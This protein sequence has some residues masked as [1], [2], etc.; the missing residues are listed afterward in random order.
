MTGDCIHLLADENTPVCSPTLTKVDNV[1]EGSCVVPDANITYLICYAANGY[2]DT[3]VVITDSLPPEVNFV[4]ASNGGAYNPGNHTVTWDIGTLGPNGSNCLTLTVKVKP[5]VS[6]KPGTT[7]TNCCEMTG[8]CMTSAVTACEDT[9]VCADPRMIKLDFNYD[10]NNDDA[11]T[12][13]GFTKFIR[14]NSGSEVNGVII[15]LGGDIQSARRTDPC[16]TYGT[17]PDN[18]YYPRAGERI[19]RDFIYGIQPSGVTITLWEL[20]VNRD[21]DITIWAYDACST[22]DVNR[23]ANWYS[24]GTYIFDTNFIGGS[25][26]WP[27]Y[28]A[29]K[30]QDL[31]KYAF[32]G[33]A[34]T[35]YLGRIILESFADPCT[36]KGQ[37]FAFVNG[38]VVVPIGDFVPTKYAHRPV[39]FDGAEDVPVNVVLSWRPGVDA[40][41]HD[42]YLGTNFN[43]VNDANRTSHS[44][45]LIYEPNH[46]ADTFDP[47]G[48][49]GFLKLD[50]TYYWRVDEV[51]IS[52]PPIWKGEVWSFTTSLCAVV[53]NFNSYVTTNAL[54]QVWKDCWYQSA[55]VT[56]AQVFVQLGTADGN[57]VRDGNSMRYDY[58]N[59][60]SPYY[61]EARADIATLLPNGFLGQDLNWLAMGAKSLTLW[62]YGQPN[63]DANEKMYVKLADNGTPVR[64]A[65]VVYSGNMNDIRET[66]WH[67]WNIALQ[68]F[69][70]NNNVNLANVKTIT[71]GFG[72]GATRGTGRVY[73][74]DIRLCAPR[75]VLSKRSAN[76]AR[77]DY[78]PPG[79]PAGD[80]VIDYREIEMMANDWLMAPPPDPNIDLYGDGTIDFKDF[81]VLAEMWLEEELWP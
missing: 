16:G 22:G 81:A 11:N 24:N 52:L 77:V 57:L 17:P 64:T 4:W 7:I 21:C 37:P 9:Y 3:N 72:N 44:N 61:S 53:E 49:A 43:D 34:T 31:Y 42:V 27:G 39:P 20:G 80:C 10:A 68:D 45:L 60:A 56:R 19:Y 63:N 73:F 46:D 69:V 59:S 8:D 75:C 55:P 65:K 58:T 78:A 32:N 62:F 18:N 38:L 71:I 29:N 2:G 50:Q 41:K 26:G 12:Q 48:A 54:E 79:N 40:N 15:D 5:C 76:F 30:P 14:A 13:A 6:V 74:E 28:E 23:V 1:P 51:N 47:C 67:E 33:T 36:A 35:D 66:K 25:A 70:D